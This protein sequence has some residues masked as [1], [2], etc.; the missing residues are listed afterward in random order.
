MFWKDGSRGS[1][2]TRMN[3]TIKFGLTGAFEKGADNVG[4]SPEDFEDSDKE[5]LLGLINDE[6]SHVSDLLDFLNS[7]AN[8]PQ[9]KLSDADFRLDM[10]VKR[11]SDVMEKAMINFGAKVRMVWELGSAEDHCHTGDNGKP[12]IGCADL[13]GIVLFGTEWD[14]LG[15]KPHSQQTNCKGYNCTCAI[16]T[17]TKRRTANGFSRV[18]DMMVAA[19]L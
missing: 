16:N 9:G 4:V 1:F 5:L 12:G 7:I 8:N 14:Q 11:Y 15:I 19:N 17:T 6:K 18:A 3:A 2:N 13:A 10:W